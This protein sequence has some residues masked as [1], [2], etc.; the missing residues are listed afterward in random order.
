MPGKSRKCSLKEHFCSRGLA[1]LPSSLR[2]EAHRQT[3]IAA[4]SFQPP[5]AP[6]CPLTDLI[7]GG[8]APWVSTL[9]ES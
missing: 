9:Q 2:R 5:A 6:H 8:R 3:S 7:M 4:F 1:S